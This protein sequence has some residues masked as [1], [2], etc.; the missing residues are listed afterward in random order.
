MRV[1]VAASRL[2]RTLLAAY[3]PGHWVGDPK[4]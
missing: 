4:R 3:P 1:M 2:E